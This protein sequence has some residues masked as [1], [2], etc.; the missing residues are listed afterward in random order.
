[1]NLT[2]L[3]SPFS[4]NSNKLCGAARPSNKK[5]P[6]FIKFE[7]DDIVFFSNLLN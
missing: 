3:Q 6:F 7:N 2:S 4:K 5:N 1:M